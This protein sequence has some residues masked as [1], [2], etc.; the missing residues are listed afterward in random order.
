[1]PIAAT[2]PARP[3]PVNHRTVYA[4]SL[5]QEIRAAWARNPGAGYS[6]LSRVYGPSPAHIR[7]IV[8][9]LVRKD[10]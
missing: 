9:G 3:E 4:F 2:P 5:L 1:M 7:S 10:K 6:A 8:L